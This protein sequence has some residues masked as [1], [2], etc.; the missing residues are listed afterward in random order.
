[1]VET[2]R[3]ERWFIYK[4]KWRKSISTQSIWCTGESVS[5]GGGSCS[6]SSEATNGPS[7]S[8]TSPDPSGGETNKTDDGDTKLQSGKF[9]QI[10]DG[11]YDLHG[12]ELY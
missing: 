7:S 11:S 5:S 9:G 10:T 1:M 4:R 12:N 6:S 2:N 8:V 3:M